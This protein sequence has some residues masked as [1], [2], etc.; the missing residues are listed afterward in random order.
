M[1]NSEEANSAQWAIDLLNNYE[2]YPPGYFF[3]SA[4]IVSAA[5]AFV[6]RCTINA[7][8]GLAPLSSKSN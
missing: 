3:Y 6:T 2:R 8:K 5:T 4:E 7:S 1:A